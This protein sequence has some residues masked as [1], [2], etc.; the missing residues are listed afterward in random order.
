MALA[1]VLPVGKLKLLEKLN[2]VDGIAGAAKPRKPKPLPNCPHSF[3]AG[4]PVL[5]EDNSTRPI[6]QIK[7]GDSVLATD[8][9]TGESG[10]RRVEVTIRTPDDRN[11]TD[12]ELAPEHGGGQVT[13]TDH[14][15][16]WSETRKSW[17]NAADLTPNDA[18]RQ[19]SGEAVS[20]TKVSH[21]K[22][23]KAAY[24][25]T[26]NDLHTY[27][28]VA[29]NTPV[30]VHNCNFDRDF[31][32]D[33]LPAYVE[34]GPTSGR[35]VTSDG[36][37]YTD[38]I[39]GGKRQNADLIN[40]VNQTLRRKGKLEG[41]ATSWRASDVEQKFA[42]MMARDGIKEADIV[43]NF[44]SGP[45]GVKLGCDDVLDALLED[46]G[47]LRVRWKE[48]GVWQTNIYGRAQS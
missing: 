44:P 10:P 46:V 36:R 24:D 16:F 29:G 4:T 37:S 32:W 12:I 2:S 45:C 22:T 1:G 48:N 40:W 42:A 26:V 33:N 41:N 14:H 19:P 27:Y 28:V 34:G 13:A 6:E 25:L 8:P 3:P 39:S 18:L 30:L 11:F 38:L 9:V 5:L 43:I 21:W 47:I 15:P 23:L 7:I 31:E 20:V 35:A 17:I